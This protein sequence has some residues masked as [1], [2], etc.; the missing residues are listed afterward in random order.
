MD[1]DG[2]VVE[3]PLERERGA[4]D[5]ERHDPLRFVA[6]LLDRGVHGVEHDVLHHEVVD[7]VPREAQLGEDRDGDRIVIELLRRV[8]D[9]ARVAR[10]IRDRDGDVAGGDA[11][12][13]MTI[14][15]QEI[16]VGHAE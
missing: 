16:E 12:E 4:D 7:R 2:A 6:D 10:G 1:R 11:G 13:A 8:E 9:R 5:E 3:P 14:R 15:A